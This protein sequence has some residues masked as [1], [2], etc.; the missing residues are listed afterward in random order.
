MGVPLHHPM[1]SRSVDH[2]AKEKARVT[3]RWSRSCRGHKG[4]VVSVI[5]SPDGSSILTA[6]TDKTARL[7]DRDGKSSSKLEGHTGLL[8]SDCV[9]RCVT[10]QR[11]K[12]CAR[13]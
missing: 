10:L 4:P 9:C 2:Q 13:G 3:A 5:F 8:S 6:S 11:E 12:Q 1:P 7:W